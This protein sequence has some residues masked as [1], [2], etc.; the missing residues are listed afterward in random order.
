MKELFTG[1]R[2]AARIRKPGKV[3]RRPGTGNNRNSLAP[4]GCRGKW[5]VATRARG[6]RVVGRGPRVGAWAIH[7][8]SNG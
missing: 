3:V 6:R 4:S 1:Y 5:G 7:Q 8:S 2:E